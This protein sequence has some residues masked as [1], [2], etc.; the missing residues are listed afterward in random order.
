MKKQLKSI[1]KKLHLQ[2]IGQEQFVA[3]L[4]LDCTREQKK[5]L[6]CYLDY[7][8]TVRELEQNFGHTNRQEMMQ[9]LKVCFALDFRIDV[10][11]CYDKNAFEQIRKQYYDYIFGF[12]ET[13][14][15]AKEENPNA[16]AIFYTTE[17]PYDISYAREMERI[18][19]FKERT[20]KKFAFERTGVYYKKDD[21]KKADTIVCL[22]EPSYFSHLGKPVYRV[23]PSALKNPKF[24]LDFSKKK[25]TNFLV[26]G[27]D[28]F[29]HKGND[30][31]VELFLKHSDWN[32]YLCGARGAE[33]AKEAG[34]R[35]PQNVHA[36]GFVDTLSEKFL[37]LAGKC[38]YLLLPSCSESPSTSVLTGLRHGILPIVTKG[39]GLDEL[40]AYCTFFDDFHLESIERTIEQAIARDESLLRRQAAEALEYADVHYTLEEYTKSMNEVLS[41]CCQ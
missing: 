39:N 7:L 13:F 33:K 34:Y 30:L 1:L 40:G 4:N 22:G 41:G 6:I 9:I 2:K 25:K 5:I 32:L 31:L 36:C 28:G 26:Y 20:G 12:G 23:W 21:E 38:Y 14:F 3:D 24:S 35:L 10:C 29:V 37:E 15:Y 17:N 27:V 8:R 16:K 11:A 19:Y 18:A